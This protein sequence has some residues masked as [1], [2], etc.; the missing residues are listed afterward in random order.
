VLFLN[1][2]WGGWGGWV[3]W[4]GKKWFQGLRRTTLLSAEGKNSEY[5]IYFLHCFENGVKM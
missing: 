1:K 4:E 2:V 5:I 3:G